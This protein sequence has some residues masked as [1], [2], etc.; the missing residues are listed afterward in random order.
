YTVN[1]TVGEIAEDSLIIRIMFRQ[2][3]K[4]QAKASGRGTVKYQ[5]AMMGAKESPLRNVQNSFMIRGNFAQA[6]A[7][8]GNKRYLRG[9]WYLIF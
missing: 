8:F 2:F 7:D 5:M 9:L 3:E 6:I 4:M 1:S